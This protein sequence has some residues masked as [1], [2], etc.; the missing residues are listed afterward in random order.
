MFVLAE[1]KDVIRV[2][3]EHFHQ[4]LTDSITVLLNRKLANKVN[5]NITFLCIISIRKHL[6]KI[7]LFVGGPKRRFM[8]SIIR[9][10]GYWTLVH[11]PRRRLLTYGSQ[12]QIHSIPTSG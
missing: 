3:P 8:H 6:I 11:I 9:F 5:K 10:N 1:M 7:S 12:V 4:S 2:T